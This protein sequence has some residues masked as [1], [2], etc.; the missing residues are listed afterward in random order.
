[1]ELVSKLF[2][3][4]STRRVIATGEAAGLT[5]VSRGADPD[6]ARG[7][8]ERPIQQV[9]AAHLRH[10]DVFYDVGANIGFFSLVA[11]RCVGKDGQVYAFEPVP[12]NADAVVQSAALNRFDTIRVFR[13]AV[14]ATSG[15]AELLLARHIGGA[16]LASADVPPD[17][18]GHLEVDVTTLDD[19]IARRGLRPPTL[20]KVDVEG[21][22]ID[23]FHGM[24]ETLRKH[25]PKI[26]FEVDDATHGG[27][28]RKTSQVT[29]L[30]TSTGYVVTDLPASY[31]GQSW[32]VRHAF[33][34]AA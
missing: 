33:A 17:M 7:T 20:V 3:A 31:G 16:A 24:A 25:R 29:A 13:E 30:L 14:G 15:R 1:M 6:F 26:V 32:H 4:L 2:G 18:N 27:L 5:L 22:E 21:A 12:Q 28:D 10:G 19:A 11:A 8:Y 34:E 23:V 9:I